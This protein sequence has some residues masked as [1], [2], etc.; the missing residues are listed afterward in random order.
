[1]NSR[2]SSQQLV[3]GEDYKFLRMTLND[4]A[5]ALI[6]NGRIIIGDIWYL[7]MKCSRFFFCQS[8]IIG[9]YND[10]VPCWLKPLH[11]IHSFFFFPQL[12]LCV[13]KA[14]GLRGSAMEDLSLNFNV[15]AGTLSIHP[16]RLMALRNS[17]LVTRSS[18]CGRWTLQSRSFSQ[19]H[20]CC[21]THSRAPHPSEDR[22]TS[23]HHHHLQWL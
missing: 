20:G 17:L 16:S 4:W 9:S 11:A 2:S 5:S 10:A 22:T 21:Q 12:V 8:K 14:K 23:L 13:A 3:S 19:S 15:S 18:D 7:N 6:L 1:M